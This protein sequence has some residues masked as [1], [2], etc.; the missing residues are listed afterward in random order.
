MLFVEPTIKKT[1]TIIKTS[2][3]C[4]LLLFFF[5]FWYVLVAHSACSL[6]INSL[7]LC[8]RD[9]VGVFVVIIVVVVNSFIQSDSRQ[10]LI[11]WDLKPSSACFNVHQEKRKAV[12]FM[13]TLILLLL[14]L[15]T[16]WN[17]IIC[18]VMVKSN[19]SKE[20]I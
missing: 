3:V 2:L 6:T 14:S 20:L 19:A 7:T 17:E 1:I 9:S 12:I 18:T 5:S 13:N 15:F 16:S 4:L 8:C 11:H 10:S